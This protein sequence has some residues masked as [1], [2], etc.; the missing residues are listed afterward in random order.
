MIHL[1]DLKAR[2]LANISAMTPEK[3]AEHFKNAGC[4]VEVIRKQPQIQ[5]SNIDT[6]WETATSVDFLDFRTTQFF[7]ENDSFSSSGKSLFNVQN[8]SEWGTP[9][10]SSFHTN[11]ASC[12]TLALAA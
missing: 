10:D 9:V 8:V 2:I 12:S 5:V 11:A 7:T 4:D 3:V 1:S 6:P